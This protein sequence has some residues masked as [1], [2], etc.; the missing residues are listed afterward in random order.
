MIKKLSILIVA[1]LLA[2]NCWALVET[3]EN[4]P[5]NITTC[6]M[7]GVRS[8]VSGDVVV[9]TDAG[10]T[11]RTIEFYGREVTGTTIQGQP[12]YGVVVDTRTSK[13][14]ATNMIGGEYVRV[15]TYGY[16][17][18]IKIAAD[19]A[20]TAGVSILVTSDTWGEAKPCQ[21]V[22]YEAG[23]K[24]KSYV[25]GT[26]ISFESEK[27]FPTSTVKGWLNW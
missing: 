1:L 25:T 7:I 3:N 24:D 4:G 27:A 19:C 16:C 12:I 6:F 15:Q 22:N 5:Q 26:S 9:Q 23:E 17:P 14:T 21:T 20:V 10:D 13:M 2:T 18:I 8:I 11:T